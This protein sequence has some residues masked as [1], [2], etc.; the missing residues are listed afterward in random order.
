VTVELHMDLTKVRAAVKSA[1]KQMRVRYPSAFRQAGLLLK[2]DARSRIHSPAGHARRGIRYDI[3]GSAEAPRLKVHPA[4]GRA[5]QAAVFAQ[6][7]RGAGTT[8]MPMKAARRLAREY[9]LPDRAARPLA[10]AIARR[11]TRGNPVMAAVLRAQR[12]HLAQIFRDTVWKP[13]ARTITQ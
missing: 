10:L 4:R 12:A 1:P 2:D 3:T 13:V 6:R 7:S 11:G 5:G 8:P 9:G